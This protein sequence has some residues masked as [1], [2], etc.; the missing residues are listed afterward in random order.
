MSYLDQAL[1]K[2]QQPKQTVIQGPSRNLQTLFPSQMKEAP[3][4]WPVSFNDKP[5]WLMV[6]YKTFAIEGFDR[7]S[8]IYSAI[9]F[10]SRAIMQTRF[11][12]MQGDDPETAEVLP[13]DHPMQQ[14]MLMPNPDMAQKYLLA[15]HNV[16]LNIAGNS[17][18]ML[19]RPSPGAMPT[20]MWPLRPDRV[21]VIP[22]PDNKVGYWYTPEGT[23]VHNGTPILSED[24]IHVKLPNPLDPLNGLGMGLS[25]MSS[26]AKNADT[27][28][29]VTNFLKRLF[30][31]GLML[32]TYL[33]FDQP[34][35]DAM[36][37]RMQKRFGEMYGGWQNWS[38]A[39]VTDNAAS[40]ENLGWDFD[41]LGFSEI[42]ERNETRILGPFGV[43]PILIGS[44]IGLLRSTY[45]NYGE[46][47]TAFWE[48][49]MT[50]EVQ[51]ANDEWNERLA[52]DGIFIGVDT[53]NVP[54]LKKNL[55]DLYEALGKAVASGVTRNSAAKELGLTI[56]DSPDNDTVYMPLTLI[57]VGQEV[58][59]KP[60]SLS[61]AQTTSVLQI[62][63]QVGKEEVSRDSALGSMRILFGLTDA[64]ANEMLGN[65]GKAS[66]NGGT[67]VKKKT[68]NNNQPVTGGSGNSSP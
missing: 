17:F 18:L 34:L 37:A 63:A 22:L 43:P 60:V 38:K 64:Q 35:D 48:D 20:A 39:V 68:P 52:G 4:L 66:S 54:A 47:R 25:P 1:I 49:T 11:R 61:P 29:A 7:N 16:Y 50:G 58:A 24:M 28:N 62:V 30:D 36:L 65:A 14:L 19:D 55:T 23:T 46:A 57:P 56:S 8:L 59:E 44:R 41:E 6:D 31:S 10:K 45:A 21:M 67:S 42:D 53:S 12:A 5:Q 9:M 27:D 32:N 15:L 51:L 13:P 3:L 2:M 40:I 33:K 26:L